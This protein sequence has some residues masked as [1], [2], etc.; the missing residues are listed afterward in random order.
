M[1]YHETFT[2]LGW[3]NFKKIVVFYGWFTGP[4]GRKK[5]LKFTLSNSYQ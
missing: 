4:N 2:A 5:I 3:N 1:K